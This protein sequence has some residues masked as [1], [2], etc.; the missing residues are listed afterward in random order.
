MRRALPLEP[1]V[2][3]PNKLVFH[4][5]V[6]FERFVQNVTLQEQGS[7]GFHYD[8]HG[9]V[10][11][12]QDTASFSPESMRARCHKLIHIQLIRESEVDPDLKL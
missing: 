10:D 9:K 5:S 2:V 8:A 1:G 12:E 7:V 3:F 11:Q 6:N 4:F